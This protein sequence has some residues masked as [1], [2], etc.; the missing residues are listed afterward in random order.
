MVA[1]DREEALEVVQA[2]DGVG[3]AEGVGVDLA[4]EVEVVRGDEVGLLRDKHD[5]GD[6]HPGDGVESAT[7]GFMSRARSEERLTIKAQQGAGA[8]GKDRGARS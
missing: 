8:R 1:V 7:L 6:W 3:P 2:E 5:R 4:V